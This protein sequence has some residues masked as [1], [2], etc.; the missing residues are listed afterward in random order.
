MLRQLTNPPESRTTISEPRTRRNRS[1]RTHSPVKK[2]K[3][4]A[5][6]DGQAAESVK[7]LD[8]LNT[9]GE[10][11]ESEE[12]SEEDPSEEL[13]QEEPQDEQQE[14]EE[15]K[16]NE[17]SDGSGPLANQV[18]SSPLQRS[19]FTGHAHEPPA[20]PLPCVQVQKMPF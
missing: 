15:Q 8:P 6:G 9:C 18:T 3:A 4:K 5:A 13:E 12:L 7:P 1:L 2:R 10:D 16:G 20:N 11:E 14:D 19:P 17:D